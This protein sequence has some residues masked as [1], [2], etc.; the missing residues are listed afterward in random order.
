MRAYLGAVNPIAD[1][2]LADGTLTFTNVAVHADV[3]RAP[4][5]YRTSWW[6]FD[7]ATGRTSKIAETSH[8]DVAG[9][10]GRPSSRRRRLYQSSAERST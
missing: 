10:V 8:D 2:R 9:G 3:A 5:A 7:N 4:R 1:P 6:T